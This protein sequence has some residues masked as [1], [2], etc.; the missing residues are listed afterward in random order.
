[1]ASNVIPLRPRTPRYSP[2]IAA[3]AWMEIAESARRVLAFTEDELRT[4]F[5]AGDL[6]RLR[7]LQSVHRDAGRVMAEGRR[8]SAWADA[9]CSVGIAEPG[10]G[11]A[12]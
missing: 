12:A 4:S 10:H 6:R 2:A 5:R 3:E 8:V 1:M 7:S 11:A 9:A